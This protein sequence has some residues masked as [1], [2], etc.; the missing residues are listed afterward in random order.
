MQK[1]KNTHFGSTL[2]SLV[3]SDIHI[4]YKDFTPGRNPSPIDFLK[5]EDFLKVYLYV[6]S[7]VPEE[8]ELTEKQL[9]SNFKKEI[10]KIQ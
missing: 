9:I 4:N 6:P 8:K 7:L 3:Q 2:S 1:I 10:K 5:L